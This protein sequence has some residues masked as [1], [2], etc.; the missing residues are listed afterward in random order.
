MSLNKLK[1][2]LYFYQSCGVVFP[3]DEQ[4]TN[5]F[6]QQAPYNDIFNKANLS[7]TPTNFTKAVSKYPSLP[8]APSFN[9]P[10]KQVQAKLKPQDIINKLLHPETSTTT[11]QPNVIQP[12]VN[13]LETSLKQLPTIDN[14]EQLKKLAK[15]LPHPLKARATNFCFA[16]GDP[17]A[18]I[19]I[20]AD[21]PLED[22]DRSGEV[23]SGEAGA[24]FDKM[25][26]SI[27]LSRADTYITYLL[28]WRP[29]GNRKIT[30]VELDSYL[31]IF[32]KHLSLLKPKLIISFGIQTTH[33]L[34]KETKDFLALRGKWYNYKDASGQLIPITLTIHPQYLI[35]TP[36]QKKYAWQDLLSIQERLNR[37]EE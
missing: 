37:L 24:L 28:P 18:K 9:K 20:I 31:P 19:L 14:I 33:L 34:T 3:L 6:V 8:A 36:G 35:K 25:L 23:F 32:L 4:A 26:A 21:S 5:K 17:T 7:L 12:T 11:T 29:P 16:S 1:E 13:N 2:L 15:D 10:H 22:D 30:P 27:N